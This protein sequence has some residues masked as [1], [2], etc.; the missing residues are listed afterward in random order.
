[1]IPNDSCLIAIKLVEDRSKENVTEFSHTD[2]K[3]QLTDSR[4][5]VNPRR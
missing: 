2:E 3:H 1:M 4:S 5:T